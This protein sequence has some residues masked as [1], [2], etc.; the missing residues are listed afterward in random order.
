M[1]LPATVR[2]S[3]NLAKNE[4]RYDSIAEEIFR[5]GASTWVREKRE[6]QIEFSGYSLRCRTRKI[7]E[8]EWSNILREQSVHPESESLRTTIYELCAWIE[9]VS[10]KD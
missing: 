5:V 4:V 6:I 8:N 9:A 10:L 3:R 1:L 2:T 7:G